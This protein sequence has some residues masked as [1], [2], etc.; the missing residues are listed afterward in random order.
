VWIGTLH[1]R[2]EPAAAEVSLNGVPQ[3]R[4]PLTIQGLRPGS[5]VVSLHLSGYDRWSW[6][7]A[8]VAGKETPLAVKLQPEQRRSKPE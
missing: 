5:R 8:V 3:G 6:S 2:S 7:V 4:T 1:V